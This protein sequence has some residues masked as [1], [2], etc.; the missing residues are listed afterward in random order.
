MAVPASPSAAQEFASRA[1]GVPPDEI[2]AVGSPLSAL[3]YLVAAHALSFDLPE[4]TV[5]APASTRHE[6]AAAYLPPLASTGR[7]I[8]LDGLF[9]LPA[10]TAADVPLV[11]RCTSPGLGD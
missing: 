11:I 10:G 5:A 1:L 2:L 8:P 4:G 7:L 6:A 3:P 9:V